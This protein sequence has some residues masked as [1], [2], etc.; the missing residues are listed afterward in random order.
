MTRRLKVDEVSAALW[1][2]LTAE[3][4]A[5]ADENIFIAR[6]EQA[7]LGPW[8]ARWADTM[9]SEG[10]RG[11]RVR[12]PELVERGH[13][14]ALAVWTRFTGESPR[15]A[16]WFAQDEISAVTQE[17]PALGELTSLARQSALRTPNEETAGMVAFF[18]AL[19][20]RDRPISDVGLPE[21]RAI[22]AR[23]GEGGRSDLPA[24]VLEAFDFY[25][26]VEAQ[27]WGTSRVYRGVLGQPVWLVRFTTDGDLAGLE[28]FDETGAWLAGRREFGRLSAWD[29]F[30]LRTRLG[31]AWTAFERPAHE[32]GMSEPDER[33]EAGQP[34]MD[35]S[36]EAQV[37]TGQLT[38]QERLL[39]A[40]EI[41][42]P[43]RWRDLAVAAFDYLWDVHLFFAADGGRPLELGPSAQG[44][45]RLGSWTKNDGRAY[46]TA[47][48]R[49]IDDG[50]YVLYFLEEENG[51][52]LAIV[53]Y[54]N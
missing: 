1:G 50:S 49:D 35:W 40:V 27:D 26:R 39:D 20:A 34:P 36:G 7:A 51:L 38:Y 21:G 32:E 11:A 48:W 14:E 3:A 28:I 10:G 18:D 12:V 16:V 42:V 41:D 4:R 6:D 19:L 45:L 33:A 30:P 47:D 54:D 13:A 52:R 37:E 15:D 44:V 5:A 46:L 23:R 9:R 25:Y 8:L 43:E 24:P 53:Q 2:L 29:R 31:G 22:D 17:D